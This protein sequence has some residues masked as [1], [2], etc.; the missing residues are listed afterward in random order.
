MSPQESG[1]PC[2]RF[3]DPGVKPRGGCWCAEEDAADREEIVADIVAAAFHDHYERLA[4]QFG[5]E[6]RE[7]SR[8]AWGDVPEQNRA[9]MRAT[10]RS[11]MAA[12]LIQVPGFRSWASLT[13]S[14]GST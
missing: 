8:K 7:D 6:T 1:C 4:P 5:Y 11:L 3:P 14:H 13:P 9:L 2:G 12:N 10:V